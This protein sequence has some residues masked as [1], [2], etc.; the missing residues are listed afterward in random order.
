MG[1]RRGQGG[2]Q[3]RRT[4]GGGGGGGR[5]GEAR[6]RGRGGCRLSNL[7]RRS[8][9]KIPR[10]ER[11]RTRTGREIWCDAA[12]TPSRTRRS[13]PKPARWAGDRAGRGGREGEKEAGHGRGG[14][15]GGASALRSGSGERSARQTVGEGAGINAGKAHI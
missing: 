10:T 8:R 13:P 4:R 11:A 15:G 3:G 7:S 2:S 6:V 14:G 12:N 9:T 1:G 5:E